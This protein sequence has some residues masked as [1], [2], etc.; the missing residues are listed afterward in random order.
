[1]SSSFCQIRNSPSRIEQTVEHSNPNQPNPVPEQMTPP[2]ADRIWRLFNAQFNTASLLCSISSMISTIYS[3]HCLSLSASLYGL[4]PPSAS[5]RPTRGFSPAPTAECFSPLLPS[6]PTNLTVVPSRH[7]THTGCLSVAT[8]TRARRGEARRPI[9]CG[10]GISSGANSTSRLCGKAC[11]KDGAGA[12][13]G[14]VK[15]RLRGEVIQEFKS[16]TNRGTLSP[17]STFFP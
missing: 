4:S 3:G 17:L 9:Y 14:K 12:G 16:H 10:R 2:C 15:E 7:V 13:W 6:P 5:A 11:R 1:M 8:D